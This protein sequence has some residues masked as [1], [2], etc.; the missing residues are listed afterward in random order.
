MRLTQEQR[1]RFDQDGYLVL[2]DILDKE[3]P[4]EK[5]APQE[6]FFDISL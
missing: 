2:E 1:D 3:S 6:R 4:P 5:S